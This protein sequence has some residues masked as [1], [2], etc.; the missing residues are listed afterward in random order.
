MNVNHHLPPKD[1]GS[2]WDAGP[3]QRPFGQ[4]D[5]TQPPPGFIPIGAGHPLAGPPVGFH[6]GA[7][8]PPGPFPPQQLP[9]A[10]HPHGQATV[11]EDLFPPGH[12]GD[13]VEIEPPR[14]K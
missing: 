3:G 6:P 13:V 11:R 8:P 10:P 1:E 7:I 5:Y 9:Q 4:F 12:N 14:S 2:R